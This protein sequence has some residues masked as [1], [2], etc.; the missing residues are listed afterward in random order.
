MIRTPSTS[1]PKLF[2]QSSCNQPSNATTTSASSSSSESSAPPP[3]FK[4]LMHKAHVALIHDSLEFGGGLSWS[5]VLA[6][7]V[8]EYVHTLPPISSLL[9]PLVPFLSCPT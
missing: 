4:E 5:S 6:W 9:P 3:T 1:T 7:K 8:M 2:Q